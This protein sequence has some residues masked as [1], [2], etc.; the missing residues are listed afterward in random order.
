MLTMEGQ[1]VISDF[2]V[3]ALLE[4]DETRCHTFVGS[5]FWIAPE[6]ITAMEDGDYDNAADIWSLGITMIEMARV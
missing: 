2:G 6:V 1:A 3:S 4:E 5:P